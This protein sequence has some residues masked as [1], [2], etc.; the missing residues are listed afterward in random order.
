MSENEMRENDLEQVTPESVGIPSEAVSR[1]LQAVRAMQFPLHGF[2]LI[3]HGKI[4]AEGYAA[5]FD[6]NRKHRMYSISKSFTSVAVGM[7]VGEGRLHL[8]DRVADFFPEYLP[9]HPSPYTMK[10]TVRD[11]LRMATPNEDNAYKW[12]DMDFIRPFFDNA[13]PKHE[14]GTVFH[15]DTNAT[16]ILC[17]IIEKLTGR[18]MLD[19]MRPVLDEIGFSK[20]AWCI[21]TPE[22]HSWTG[23]GILCT[24]RDLARFGL[25]CLNRG[26][27]RGK[28]LVDRDYMTA[29]TTRQISTTVA[30]SGW[31]RNGYGYQFWM[32]QDGG[33]ACLGM[34][35]QF[36]FMMPKYD[37]VVVATEDLQAFS[38]ADDG[39]RSAVFRMMEQAADEPLPENPEAFRKLQSDLKEMAI[40][41]PDGAEASPLAERISGSVYEL[42]GNLF[43]FEWM[44]FDFAE[45]RLVMTYRKPSGVHTLTFGIK[46]YISQPFPDV[47][48]GEQL[49]K[50]KKHYESIAAAAWD[51]ENTL[52]GMIYSVDAY[53]GSIKMQLTFREDGLT[54][55]W[56]KFAENFF[57]DYR[58]YIAGHRTEKETVKS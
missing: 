13:M 7:M 29:A 15:Y 8:E 14:P 21:R 51:S 20:D 58:G 48:S 41:L 11:L 36:A 54:V 9:P 52:I 50:T 38:N 16:V 10:A 28:Q 12:G 19:Y 56:T 47:Y 3:R 34:G 46:K 4:A 53:L 24:P 25:L 44:K 5:P 26:N 49:E 43:G 30:D 6:R 27:W 33:F 22:G 31:F 17:A 55:F 40:P 2:L 18:K 32:L 35:G 42:E 1:F 39:V 57:G 37:A 23:S 45:D